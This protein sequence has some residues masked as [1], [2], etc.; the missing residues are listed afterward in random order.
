M[1]VAEVVDGNKQAVKVD[2]A[3]LLVA[4]EVEQVVEIMED[5]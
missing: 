3:A 4:E 1:L 5:L 2:L